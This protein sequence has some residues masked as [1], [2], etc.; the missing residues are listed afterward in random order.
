MSLEHISNVNDDQCAT[1]ELQYRDLEKLVKQCK[2]N[3]RPIDLVNNEGNIP[4]TFSCF[5]CQSHAEKKKSEE[6]DD[7]K[8]KDQEEWFLQHK[9]EHE[10]HWDNYKYFRK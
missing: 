9:L 3:K 8:E 6:S 5:H 1:R 10:S 4:L 2:N 7:E